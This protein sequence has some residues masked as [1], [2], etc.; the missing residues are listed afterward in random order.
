MLGLSRGVLMPADADEPFNTMSTPRCK[1]RYMIG[2]HSG[3]DPPFSAPRIA[4]VRF[5]EAIVC[6]L[7]QSREIQHNIHPGKQKSRSR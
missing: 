3:P 4:V 2:P 1:S 7:S 6:R 5:D